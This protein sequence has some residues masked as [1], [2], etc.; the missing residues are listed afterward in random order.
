MA[1]ALW[2]AISPEVTSKKV[3]FRLEGGSGQSEFLTVYG[4]LEFG[5][6]LA[7]LLP[8]L[9]PDSLEPMFLTCLLIHVSLVVFR[10]IGFFLFENIEAMT[11]KLATGEWVLMIVAAIIWFSRKVPVAP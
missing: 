3:G 8:W 10:T 1:L 2:C 4:G 11:W 6:A 7:F 9:K 5:M